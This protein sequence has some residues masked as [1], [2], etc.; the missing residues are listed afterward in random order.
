MSGPVP[1]QVTTNK[2]QQHVDNEGSHLCSVDDIQGL[3][4]RRGTA[5]QHPT[6]FC[7]SVK[8]SSVGCV[9]CVDIIASSVGSCGGMLSRQQVHQ[10][11]MHNLLRV[12]RHV[13]SLSMTSGLRTHLHRH[14]LHE[15]GLKMPGKQTC[16]WRK[17]CATV[18][19]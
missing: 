14:H 17:P 8:Y 18:Y 10:L 6:F 5:A 3:Q 1:F 15:N 16:V 9:L 12:M 13:N 7:S 19:R 2:A 11:V 4:A